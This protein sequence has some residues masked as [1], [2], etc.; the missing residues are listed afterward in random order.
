M[1]KLVQ[2]ALVM[3]VPGWVPSHS[4]PRPGMGMKRG[5]TINRP[6]ALKASSTIKGCAMRASKKV[7]VTMPPLLVTLNLPAFGLKSA[8]SVGSRM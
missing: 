5:M 4:Q 2:R 7:W 8:I 1:L 6:R 3:M